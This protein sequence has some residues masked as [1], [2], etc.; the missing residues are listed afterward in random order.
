VSPLPHFQVEFFQLGHQLC[1]FAGIGKTPPEFAHASAT[2]VAAS[3]R[4]PPA[5]SLSL[6][7]WNGLATRSIGV[8]PDGFVGEVFLQPEARDFIGQQSS[9]PG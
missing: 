7:S 6:N 9:S 2:A 3:S 4:T 8:G 5:A 1:L